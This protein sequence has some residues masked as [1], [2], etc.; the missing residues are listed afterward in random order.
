MKPSKV[1][2]EIDENKQNE[3]YEAKK[4]RAT[5]HLILIR[6]GQ[7]NTGGKTDAERILTDLGES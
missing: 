4:S 2:N 3:E 7:Y 1:T 5:R 6:H